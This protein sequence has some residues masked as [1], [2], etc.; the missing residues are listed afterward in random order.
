[1]VTVE[2]SSEALV[3]PGT[4]VVRFLRRLGLARDP[5]WHLRVAAATAG[6]PV[7]PKRDSGVSARCDM[8]SNCAVSARD[9]WAEARRS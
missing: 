9:T 4:L 2:S 5:G 8:F 7:L 3:A 6:A 1:M